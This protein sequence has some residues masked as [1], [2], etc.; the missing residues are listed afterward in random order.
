[1]N[2]ISF[3]SII[4]NII[5]AFTDTIGQFN[6]LSV[7]KSINFLKISYWQQTW[8]IIIIETHYIP[9]F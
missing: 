2:S 6:A 5:N 4:C 8:T 1:M 9:P 3:E 7:N